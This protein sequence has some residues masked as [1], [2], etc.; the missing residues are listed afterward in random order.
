MSVSS[1]SVGSSARISWFPAPWV[2]WSILAG[3]GLT[4]TTTI[5]YFA[6]A[7][8]PLQRLKIAEVVSQTGSSDIFVDS[9]PAQTGAEVTT[10]QQILTLENSRVGLRH[11]D[12]VLARLGNQSSVTLERDC[13]QLGEGQVVV[14]ATQGCIGAAIV[15]GQDAVY[16]LERLGTLGEVKVLSGRVEVSVPSNPAAQSIALTA[17]QKVTL[18]L[19]G[20]EIGPIRLMLPAEV[21]SILQGE[22]FQGFQL[23]LAQQNTIAGLPPAAI[24]PSPSPAPTPAPAKPPQ[25]TQSPPVKAAPQPSAPAHPQPVAATSRPAYS[26]YSTDS[27][28]ASDDATRSTYNRTYRRRRVQEPSQDYYVY[29]RKWRSSYAGNSYRRRAPV[30]SPSYPASDHTVPASDLPTVH[31]A[32]QPETPAPVEL[33]PVTP[34]VT[35]PL[36]PP[37][38]VEPPLEAPPGQ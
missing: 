34:P 19:T 17:N 14:S 23:A 25:V 33:P 30:Y 38:M 37:V 21:G 2:V 1:S 4:L 27:Y 20:D 22:L 10:G 11:A 18:S 24:A 31:E 32:P 15:R 9:K 28:T 35:E 16:V 3:C 26:D 12:G 6:W 5:L 29:R 36:P 7:S 13:I 8:Q